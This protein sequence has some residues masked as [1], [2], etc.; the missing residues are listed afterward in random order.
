MKRS[1]YYRL[2]AEGEPDP[3]TPTCGVTSER[4]PRRGI[5]IAF[6]ACMTWP[7]I[8]VPLAPVLE[9]L[10]RGPLLP[11]LLVLPIVLAFS[12]LYRSRLLCGAGRVAR[13]G[14][15]VLISY[16][17]FAVAFAIWVALLLA[18]ILVSGASIG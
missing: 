6:L 17:V 4:S 10:S 18:L 14:L 12:F 15:L 2:V 13:V 5:A 7:F 1:E 11:V 9:R 16:A 3:V 8:A